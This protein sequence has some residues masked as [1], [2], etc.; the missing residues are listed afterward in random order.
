MSSNQ[1]IT[2]IIA[3]FNGVRTLEKCIKSCIEQSFC[4]KELIIID[5]GST[6]GTLNLLQQYSKHIHYWIS[7]PD[8]GI[9]DAWNKALKISTG[10]WICFIG[11][12]DWWYSSETL[13]SLHNLSLYSDINFISGK[14]WLVNLHGRKINL[15]GQAW[16]YK[17]LR[18]GMYIAHPGALHHKSLFNSYGVFREKFKIAGD[19]DFFIRSGKAIKSAFLEEP[20]VCMSN[21]GLSNSNFNLTFYEGFLVLKES[22]DFSYLDA[23]IFYVLSHAKMIVKKYFLLLKI[24]FLLLNHGK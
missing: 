6:D 10:D 16:D 13:T 7:E 9:Y 24:N 14:A 4:E 1:K 3:V 19:Y 17:K 5:A 22:E 15:I 2:I 20:I 11:S 12:D 18:Y 23:I 8:F 21:A